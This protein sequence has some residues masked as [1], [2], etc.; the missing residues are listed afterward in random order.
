MTKSLPNPF[1]LRNGMEEAWVMVRQPY[2]AGNDGN[3]SR[4]GAPV[5]AF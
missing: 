5:A 4:F 1:I 2:M 3:A